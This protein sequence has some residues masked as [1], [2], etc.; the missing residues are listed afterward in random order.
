MIKPSIR[1]YRDIVMGRL[2]AKGINL[3]S[4]HYSVVLDDCK[5]IFEIMIQCSTKKIISV[6]FVHNDD[7]FN[8]SALNIK[9]LDPS[10]SVPM[11]IISRF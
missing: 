9:P 7:L 5:I 8:V 3:L 4:D 2:V 11:L 6:Y 10:F 1:G